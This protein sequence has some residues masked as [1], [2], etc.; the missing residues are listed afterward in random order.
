[1]LPFTINESRPDNSL[2]IRITKYELNP[3]FDPETFS[4]PERI[5]YGEPIGITP[6]TLPEHIY[7]EEDGHY[8]IGPQRYWAW[9]STPR[10]A[11]H[12]MCC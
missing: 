10:K 8:T 1:M 12:W 2:K 7:K 4:N 9:I 3:R 6:A 11:G 5:K